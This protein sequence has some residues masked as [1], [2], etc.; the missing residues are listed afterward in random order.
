MDCPCSF[1]LW[2]RPK[3]AVRDDVPMNAPFFTEQEEPRRRVR[4]L[5]VASVLLGSAA[6]FDRHHDH[7]QGWCLDALANP[8][9]F[10]MVM[11]MIRDLT[12]PSKDEDT[13]L[14]FWLRRSRGWPDS[15]SNRLWGATLMHRH[16]EEEIV[17]NRPQEDFSN[18]VQL[19]LTDHDTRE[20]MDYCVSMR[21]DRNFGNIDEPFRQATHAIGDFPRA[22]WEYI[23]YWLYGFDLAK[24]SD[25]QR[26]DVISRPLQR[27]ITY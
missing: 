27:V 6:D 16:S 13:Q 24:F 1:L 12:P 10:R 21:A 25:E 23:G 19:L 11:E 7:F 18:L 3:A 2:V 8:A 26:A 15:L 14:S 9:D 17:K 4:A 22:T 20:L 5:V